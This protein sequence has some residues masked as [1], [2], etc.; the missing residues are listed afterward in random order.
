MLV[1]KHLC[2]ETA[3]NTDVLTKQQRIAT[4]DCVGELDDSGGVLRIEEDM[5]HEIIHIRITAC[6]DYK[7]SSEHIIRFALALSIIDSI[8][9]DTYCEGL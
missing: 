1:G 3:I 2:I 8:A 4:T 6:L 5:L 7:F 9:W